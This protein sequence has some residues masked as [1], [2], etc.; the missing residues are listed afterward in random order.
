ML[1]LN[2]GADRFR[3]DAVLQLLLVEFWCRGVRYP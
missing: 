3:H 2:L 1:S